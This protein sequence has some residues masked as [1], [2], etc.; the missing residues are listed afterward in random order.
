MLWIKD[1]QQNALGWGITAMNGGKQQRSL[2][3]QFK[4]Y[5]DEKGL[6]R[7]KGRIDNSP[8]DDSA[9]YS[10][11]LPKKHRF[12]DLIMDILKRRLHFGC[13]QTLAE[14]CQS[15]WIPIIRRSVN[16]MLRKCILCKK[17]VG[18]PVS[19]TK[20]TITF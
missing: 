15:F 20:S 14:I 5:Q 19:V 6:L 10:A 13:S 16:R 11:L 18:Q 3:K 9:K 1:V 7:C 8:I 2:Q 12:N 4:L 17:I